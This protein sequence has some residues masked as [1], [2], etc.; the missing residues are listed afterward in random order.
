MEEAR[1][2]RRTG[3]RGGALALRALGTVV[4]AAA[5]GC[6]RSPTSASKACTEIGCVDGFS[7]TVTFGPGAFPMGA[8]QLDVTADGATLSCA[9]MVPVPKL[10]GGGDAGPQCAPGVTLVVG[11]AARCAT[12]QLPGG[13]VGEQCTPIAGASSESITVAGTP[14]QV[15]LRQ[16]VAGA[17]IL[18]RS[19]APSYQVSQPNGPGCDPLCQQAAAQWV[20]PTDGGSGADGPDGA[21]DGA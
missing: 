8:H 12:V 1:Q 14:A 18:D 21:P 17:V 11:P 9:F 16:T 20:L 13:A 10:P 6:A 19:V 5:V 4:V 3:R 7:A 15:T 2:D